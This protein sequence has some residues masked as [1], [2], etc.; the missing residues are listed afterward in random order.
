MD[1][2]TTFEPLT[3]EELGISEKTI[4]LAIFLSNGEEVTF[5]PYEN[6]EELLSDVKPFCSEQ[7]KLGNMEQSEADEI[8][9]KYDG[10]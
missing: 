5:G 1:G 4:S 9:N 8:L 2:G 6:V 10:K 7:V 3:D